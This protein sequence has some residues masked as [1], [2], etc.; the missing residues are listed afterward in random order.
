MVLKERFQ[1]VKEY[2][3]G[4]PMWARVTIAFIL[5]L[6]LSL[7][8]M[9]E[10]IDNY[11]TLESK[12]RIIE[13]EAYD[14]R[15]EVLDSIRAVQ[16]EAESKVFWEKSLDDE[17]KI[18][19]ICDKYADYFDHET[20]ISLFKLHDHGDPL[21][22]ENSPM[23][24][25]KWSTLNE[26]QDN[27]I[28]EPAYTGALWILANTIKEGFVY[29]PD[30]EQVPDYW[31]G[32]EKAFHESIGSQSTAFVYVKP[33]DSSRWFIAIHWDSKDPYSNPYLLQIRLEQFANLISEKIYD[34][35]I[36]L[37]N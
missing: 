5:C 18:R 14:A 31:T 24:T 34:V 36:H 27:F 28:A 30:V 21:A 2:L 10:S 32:R 37:Q 8:V 23:I 11:M 20:Q 3:S 7:W 25:V 1:I 16:R 26:I 33:T 29:L 12:Q 4:L 22:P 6:V 19:S 17:L 9:R 35:P 13:L 15:K